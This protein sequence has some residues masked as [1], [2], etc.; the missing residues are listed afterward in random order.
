MKF[1]D[2]EIGDWVEMRYRK[3]RITGRVEAKYRATQ[4][5]TDHIPELL[6]RSLEEKSQADI[7]TIPFDEH[8]RMTGDD[9]K[10][11]KPT[12]ITDHIHSTKLCYSI[13]ISGEA[14]DKMQEIGWE[15]KKLKGEHE[16]KGW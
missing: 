1:N 9:S 13:T 7:S 3:G 16:L 8:L 10:D 4:I 15:V 11:R 5:L 2:L 14:F 12:L 6:W